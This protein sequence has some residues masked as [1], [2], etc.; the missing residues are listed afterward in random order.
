MSLAHPNA[1]SYC[2]TFHSHCL[3]LARVTT[4]L[5]EANTRNAR[6]ASLQLRM[7]AGC[8]GRARPPT[9]KCGAPRVRPRALDRAHPPAPSECVQ[10]R[11][12]AALGL[13][14]SCH[15]CSGG[16]VEDSWQAVQDRLRAHAAEGAGPGA[17]R[18]GPRA[19]CTGRGGGGVPRLR[20]CGREKGGGVACRRAKNRTCTKQRTSSGR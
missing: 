5:P 3:Y 2:R 7:L 15:G 16:Q 1:L 9:G 13:L 20:I 11:T 10:R 14:G 12:S 17:G 6:T 8:T 4:V 18:K 19:A